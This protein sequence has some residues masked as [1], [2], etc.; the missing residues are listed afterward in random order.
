M[1]KPSDEKTAIR[2]KV[3]DK[4]KVIYKSKLRKNLAG[5]VFEETGLY[6]SQH[7]PEFNYLPTGDK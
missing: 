1:E 7:V 2:F 6:H 5:K 4:G 3:D